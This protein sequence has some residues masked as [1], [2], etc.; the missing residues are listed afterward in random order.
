MIFGKFKFEVSKKG[1]YPMTA[2]GVIS[3]K[4]IEMASGKSLEVSLEPKM[5]REHR[6]D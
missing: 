1:L 4:G 2:K 5:F 3:V 6:M